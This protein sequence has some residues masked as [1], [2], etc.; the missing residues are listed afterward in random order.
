[1]PQNTLRLVGRDLI[2]HSYQDVEGIVEHNK[3]LANAGPQRGDF[4]HIASIPLNIINQWLNEEWARGNL[5][6]QMSGREFDALV[7]RKL[8]DSDWRYLRTD[9]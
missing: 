4:R 6:L 8:R 3:A 9:K 2:V 1:V 7:A 5:D